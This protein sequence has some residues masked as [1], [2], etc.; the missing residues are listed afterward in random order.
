MFA[1]FQRSDGHRRM[2][3]VR[4]RDRHHLHRGIGDKCLPV[5]GRHLEAEFGGAFA[6][7]ALVGLA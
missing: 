6:R 3:G 5:G 4:R 7:E 2:P 1:G